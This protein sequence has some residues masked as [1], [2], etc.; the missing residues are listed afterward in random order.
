[1]LTILAVAL[2]FDY[3]FGSYDKMS[4]VWNLELL[5]NWRV[6][7]LIRIVYFE[8]VGHL[9]T[10]FP[11]IEKSDIC[12]PFC[13]QFDEKIQTEFHSDAESCFIASSSRL[14]ICGNSLLSSWL[15]SVF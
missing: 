15:A 1:M 7:S 3:Q 11:Y 2:D 14:R 9:S 12:P 4:V 5:M 6:L 8:K 10:F 13:T